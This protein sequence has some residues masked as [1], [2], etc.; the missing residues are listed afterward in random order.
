MK[1]ILFIATLLIS[2]LSLQA[3]TVKELLTKYRNMPD[4][5][6][7]EI[8]GKELKEA[9]EIDIPGILGRA[10]IKHLRLRSL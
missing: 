5:Q 2:S 7:H 6:Y 8:K 9:I 10:V 3:L 4:V 1:R